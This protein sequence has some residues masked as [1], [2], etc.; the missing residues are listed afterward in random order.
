MRR[1]EVLIFWSLRL[2]KQSLWLEGN[3][4]FR[5]F[6]AQSAE[7][8]KG[9]F[10]LLRDFSHF[11]KFHVAVLSGKCMEVENSRGKNCNISKNLGIELAKQAVSEKLSVFWGDWG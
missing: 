4:L 9:N 3:H 8:T 5:T 1:K 2:E 7:K 10:L 6:L 11:G